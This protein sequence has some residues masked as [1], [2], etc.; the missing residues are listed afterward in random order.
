MSAFVVSVHPHGD[1]IEVAVGLSE[2]PMDERK[3]ESR[4]VPLRDL[5][6]E[7]GSES[8]WN[9]KRCSSLHHFTIS[10]RLVGARR[11]ELRTSWSRTRRSTRL[12]H[13]PNGDSQPAE[14]GAVT[15]IALDACLLRFCRRRFLRLQL[16][17]QDHLVARVVDSYFLHRRAQVAALD[18]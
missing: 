14:T 7:C 5:K 9:P 15:S 12:S 18:H 11:F 17:I 6:T 16:E 3:N 10:G 2:C 1:R 4:Q 8:C 13:A